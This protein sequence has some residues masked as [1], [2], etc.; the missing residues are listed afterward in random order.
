MPTDMWDDYATKL[1]DGPAGPKIA[2][3]PTAKPDMFD[4]YYAKLRPEVV[5]DELAA[6]TAKPKAVLGQSVDTP[7]WGAG[8]SLVNGLLQGFAPQAAAGLQTLFNVGPEKSY[9]ERVDRIKKQQKEYHE[10]HPGMA[11]ATEVGGS[12][13]TALPMMATG[14]G[15]LAPLGARVAGAFP[16]V[17]AGLVDFLSGASSGAMKVPSLAARGAVE[18]ATGAG[19]ASGLSDAPIGDQLKTGAVIGGAAG[20]ILNIAGN[21]LASK[22]TPTAADSAQAL[23][24]QGVPVR[25]GQIPGASPVTSTLDKV[26]S[27]GK[28]AEQAEAFSEALTGHAGLPAKNI[29]QS[30]VT[31]NDQRVGKVMNDIQSVYD[32]PALEPG[33]LNHLSTIRADAMKNMTV[34]NAK[35]VDQLIG[36]IEENAINP[37][38]GSIYKNITQKNGVLDN[39]SKDKDISGAVHSVREALDDAW[40]RSLPADKKTAWDTARKEYKVTR[41]ID[42][43]MGGAAATGEYNPK[44]LLGAV[45][46]RWG[47]VDNA[48]ELG[49]LARG[50]QFLKAPGEGV[51]SGHPT[52][53]K[54]I[55]HA[56]LPAA[57]VVAA[58][59]GSKVFSHYGP[60]MMAHIAAHP[61]EMTLPILSGIGAYLAGKGGNAL[62]NSPRATQYLLDVSQGSRAPV[63]RGVNPALPFLVEGANRQ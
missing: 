16:R 42:D 47:N 10:N 37:I 31:K 40:G 28:N 25:A 32:I 29:D 5:A 41:A 63:M 13:A 18:G 34:D 51:L 26:F 52:A 20:P 62:L 21:A 43:S 61:A 59:Q 27:K 45:E 30:W 19:I 22:F 54:I 7:D 11:L 3:T 36:K 33:L 14:A 58:D 39:F 6:K 49:E 50:A 60:E 35:K 12:I 56:A 9:A 44:K 53:A 55:T 46:K 57:A 8:Q 17:G 15:A 23:I 38:N 1:R 24:N 48:G 2:V 4:E